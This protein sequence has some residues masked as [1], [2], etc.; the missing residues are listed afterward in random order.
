MPK[1]PTPAHQCEL[2]C[3]ALARPEDED[4]VRGPDEYLEADEASSV[5]FREDDEEEEEEETEVVAVD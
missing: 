5:R 4:V 1:L 2:S 3:S